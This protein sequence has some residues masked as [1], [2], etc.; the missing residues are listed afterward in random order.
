MYRWHTLPAARAKAARLGYRGALYAW[1]SADDGQDVTPSHVLSPSGDLVRI[2]VGEEEQHVSAAVAY[3]IWTYWRATEDDGFLLQAGAEMVVE[4]A[5]FWASRAVL[6]EDGQRHIRGVIGPDEYHESIDDDAYTNGMAAWNLAF[7]AEL[8]RTLAERWP[9]DRERLARRLGVEPG[10]PARWDEAAR[11]MYTGFDPSTGLFEQFQ[12]YFGLEEFDLA[13]LEPRSAP[14]EAL[15]GRES[16]QRSKLVKQPDVVLL[17]YLLPDRYPLSVQRA[18]FAYYEPRTGH[19]SSLSPPIHAAM[20]ARLG[21]LELAARYFRQTAEIDLANNM[22]NAAGGVHAG[23]LAGLWH[24]A[25][26]G[27]AGLELGP[28]GP[29]FR[30]RLPRGWSRMK[31]RCRWRGRPIHVTLGEE[32]RARTAAEPPE[33]PTREVSP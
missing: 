6:E 5:R 29:R 24:A 14:V 1:E 19:G 4:T 9:S 3:G 21:Q 8:W 26:F 23:A 13:M 11:A 7:A 27:F 16:I 2:K 10:E 33:N 17:H 30:A 15:L 32:A 20:A 22:G 18:N 28:D 31:V 12:G 25:V